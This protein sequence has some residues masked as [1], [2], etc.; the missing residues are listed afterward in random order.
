MQRR[1]LLKGAAAGVAVGLGRR[2]LGVPKLAWADGEAPHL[3]EM[4]SRPL[5]YEST[6]DTFT[7]RITPVDHFYL[8]NH[9]DAPV[10]D[11]AT[12]ASTWKLELTG[13]LARPRTVTLA[14]LQKMKQVTVE[15]VLQCAGNGRGLFTPRVPGVQWRWG[16][17]GNAE[18]EGVRLADLLAAA[19]VAKDAKHLAVQGMEKPTLDKTPPFVRGL[20]IEKAMHPDTIIALKMNGQPISPLHGY[21]ARLIVPGWVAD[22]WIK[23]I[24]RIEARPDEP[25]GFWYETGYRFPVTPGKPGEAIPPDQMK[26]MTKLFVKSL[27]GSISP[28]DTLPS[29][30]HELVGVAFSGEAQI[31]KVEV[32]LDGGA[33]WQLA[34]LDAH[35]SKYGFRLFR[36][37]WNAT[38]GKFRIG[39]RAT[40]SAGAVQPV[41]PVW[42]PS[43][44]LFNA[45]DLADVVVTA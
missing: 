27:I 39:S 12:W 22:D 8:R 45:I 35:A 43:G 11:P 23:W 13:T 33:T 21:P 25:K 44:Y 29:G 5:N 42:N 37:A 16:A 1:N 14:D 3:Y 32:T 4:S 34:K 36:F 2:W 28:G 30:P 17:M 15:A 31:K 20:P 7:T 41:A 38:A 6:R 9:F 24:V 19:G 18:W 26:P 40:D 10:G